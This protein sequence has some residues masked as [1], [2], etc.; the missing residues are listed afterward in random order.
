MVS[1]ELTFPSF[2]VLRLL[3]NLGY[4]LAPEVEFTKASLWVPTPLVL[5]IV[6]GTV[7][8]CV[9]Q[10]DK[11]MSKRTLES[12]FIVTFLCSFCLV[13]LLGSFWPS[14]RRASGQEAAAT[15]V[16]PWNVNAEVQRVRTVVDREVGAG[17]GVTRFG[18]RLYVY[19]DLVFARPRVGVIKEFDLELR[20]TGRSV[21]L[22]RQGK[23]LLIHP[24]GLT[25]HEPW[26]TFLGDTVLQKA[27]I[28]RLD[29][30]QA[31]KDGN[32]DRAVLGE[33]DDDAAINGTRPVFVSLG[34]KTYLATADYGDVHPEIR[35]Y[36]TDRLL[37]AGRSSAPGVVVHRVLCG[38][39]NQNLHWDE[40]LGHLIC[41]QNVTAGSGWRLDRLDL[42]RG[43]ADGR[44]HGPG[45][46]V[47]TLTFSPRNEL[48]GFLPIAQ[49]TVLFVVASREE[50]L[51]LGRIR[52]ATHGPAR[53]EATAGHPSR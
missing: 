6:L 1:P 40:S 7:P 34:G 13:T 52:E 32:L 12:S 53:A 22:M 4:K 50:T 25:R 28:Y 21:R 11:I 16:D 39:F 35:L 3:R 30:E 19:G 15:A 47:R 29:W 18:D 14:D 20:P 37:A 41:I 10:R 36:D 51:V 9:E 42:A 17:Q 45:V 31:W 38:P 26:G 23:P 46:R 44:A 49:D 24:T 33:I 2:S 43:V 48:E 27:R 8:V 5:S